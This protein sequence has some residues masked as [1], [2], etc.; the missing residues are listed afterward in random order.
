MAAMDYATCANWIRTILIRVCTCAPSGSM[1]DPDSM[2]PFDLLDAAMRDPFL[3]QAFRQ[4][5]QRHMYGIIAMVCCSWHH[6]STTSNSSLKVKV[7]TESSEERGVHDAAT[8][9]ARWLQRNI[10]NLTVLDISL[11]RPSIMDASWDP[12]LKMPRDTFVPSAM[13]RTI[14]SATQLCSLRLDMDYCYLSEP[15]VGVSALT[16]LTNL[17]LSSCHLGGPAFY[18]MLALTQLRALDLNFVN[19]QVEEEHQIMP[20]LTSSLTNLTSL[21]HF[22]SAGLANLEKALAC[23]RSLPKLVGLDIRGISIPSGKLQ[24][25]LGELPITGIQIGLDD[26]AHV[27]EVAEWLEHRLPVT[28]RLWV[29]TSQGTGR[30]LGVPLSCSQ[31]KWSACSPPSGQQVHSSRFWM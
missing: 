17:A 14:T 16:N 5:D 19:V 21:T 10:G 3:Q 26:P 12:T 22:K 31:A 1:S 20:D 29:C 25:L 30:P 24:N 2:C 15:F 18:S 28:L 7:S 27:S 4:L 9:F 8:S 6:L 11:W 13:L 23:I